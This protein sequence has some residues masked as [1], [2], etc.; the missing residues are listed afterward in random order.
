MEGRLEGGEASDGALVELKDRAL[1]SSRHRARP[2]RT[3]AL[4]RESPPSH[5]PE[6]LVRGVADVGPSP[7]V[8]KGADL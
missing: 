3:G 7:L 5:C 4:S 6:L 8:L 2:G 1:P